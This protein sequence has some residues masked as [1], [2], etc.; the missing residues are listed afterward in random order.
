MPRARATLARARATLARATL[1][2][3]T[4]ATTCYLLSVNKQE[5]AALTI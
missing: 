3:P 4:N 1:A 5:I 2:R